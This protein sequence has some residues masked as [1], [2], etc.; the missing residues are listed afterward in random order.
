MCLF[1]HKKANQYFSD[2]FYGLTQLPFV[3]A[4]LS[5]FLRWTKVCKHYKKER[6][7]KQSP[8]LTIHRKSMIEIPKEKTAEVMFVHWCDQN[9]W[10]ELSWMGKR[11]FGLIIWE[12]IIYMVV[13]V[14]QH[15]RPWY[16]MCIWESLPP[17]ILVERSRKNTGSRIMYWNLRSTSNDPHPKSFIIT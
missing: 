10:Q 5:T 3:S 13:Y 9:V 7:S 1:Q 2:W 12:G 6:K 4:I 14:Q 11:C 15:M 17:H 8:I 16:K